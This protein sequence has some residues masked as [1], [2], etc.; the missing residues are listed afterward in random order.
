MGGFGAMP[1]LGIAFTGSVAFGGSAG[2]GTAVLGPGAGSAGVS[3]AGVGADAA[4]AA[5]SVSG[6]AAALA[7]AASAFAASAAA[8]QGGCSSD[9][10]ATGASASLGVGSAIATRP[11]DESDVCCQ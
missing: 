11:K 1:G 7:L 2:C 9:G 4:D 10:L 6:G 5:A 8:L 3:V